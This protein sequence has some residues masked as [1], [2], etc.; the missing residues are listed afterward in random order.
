M[1]HVCKNLQVLFIRI[2]CFGIFIYAAAQIVIIAKDYHCASKEYQCLAEKA[3]VMKD[4]A[5]EGEMTDY[6]TDFEILRMINEDTAGWIILP[7]SK[8]NYPIVKSEDN[9]EYLTMTF[10]GNPSNSGAIFMD[11]NCEG[12]FSSQNTVIYGHN[13]KNGS[14]FRALNSMTDSE[15]FSSHHTFWIDM[16]IGFEDY[17]VIA[18]YETTETDPI[19]W[20]VVFESEETYEK[21]L[22]Q[23]VKRCSYQCQKYSFAKNTITLSTCRGKSGG[24]GRFVVHLQK[25][26]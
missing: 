14:M 25:K 22:Q 5:D 24:S 1:R 8:I 15:Y 7:D 20:K 21:W 13:M 2:L 19:S 12:D 3:V 17:E 4:T 16:G 6:Q 18:C 10:E 9:A 11:M 26:D 23:I